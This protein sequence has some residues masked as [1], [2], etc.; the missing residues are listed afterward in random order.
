MPMDLCSA[1]WLEWLW[2]QDCK[3]KLA[4][5]CSNTTSVG[6]RGQFLFLLC[7]LLAMRLLHICLVFT[8]SLLL[9]HHSES[10]YTGT[11]LRPCGLDW[12]NPAL[13]SQSLSH[14]PDLA[15]LMAW[16]QE[17][18]WDQS[19]TTS[20]RPLPYLQSKNFFFLR[21]YNASLGLQV[22]TLWPKSL[23]DI[24]GSQ[25]EIRLRYWGGS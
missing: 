8:W 18:I 12:A 22:A 5:C 16:V 11:V 24:S 20:L 6:G 15:W 17:W 2:S 21:K 23:S 13:L 25:G 14:D 10:L 7:H 19:W 4:S 3:V 9:G 1:T